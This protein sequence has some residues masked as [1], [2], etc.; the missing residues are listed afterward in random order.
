VNLADKDADSIVR[1]FDSHEFFEKLAVVHASRPR[2]NASLILI[3]SA[4]FGEVSFPFR[5]HSSQ[6]DLALGLADHESKTSTAPRSL[7]CVTT[8]FLA[9]L[10]QGWPSRLLLG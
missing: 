10:D 7:R 5:R 2:E 9:F 6:R 1:P 8:P 3:P 4:I